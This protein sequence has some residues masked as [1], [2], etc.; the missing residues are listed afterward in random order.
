MLIHTISHTEGQEVSVCTYIYIHKITLLSKDY[1]LD[2]GGEG[3]G[4]WL[5]QS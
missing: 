4:D 2:I 5:C 3:G 1:I